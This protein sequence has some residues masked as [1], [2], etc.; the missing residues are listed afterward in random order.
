[1]EA[2]GVPQNAILC[3]G[4][5]N[6][7]YTPVFATSVTFLR[8]AQCAGFYYMSTKHAG[9]SHTCIAIFEVARGLVRAGAG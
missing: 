8:K 3:Y 9:P 6:G 7:L 1:M 4:R 2:A 5:S